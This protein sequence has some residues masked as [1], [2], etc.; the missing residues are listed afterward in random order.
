MLVGSRGDCGGNESRYV[1]PSHRSHKVGQSTDC[2]D[3][4]KNRGRNGSAPETVSKRIAR[5]AALS[6]RPSSSAINTRMCVSASTRA[7]TQ[8]S[9][10]MHTGVRV[11]ALTG[12]KRF[13]SVREIGRRQTRWLDTF[14]SRR[15]FN[16]QQPATD[17]L[18]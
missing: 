5:L 9:M 16:R 1:R 13:C 11:R 7:H 6:S 15:L 12:V 2:G 14:D 10:H 8:L 17:Q 18:L 4:E 3:V